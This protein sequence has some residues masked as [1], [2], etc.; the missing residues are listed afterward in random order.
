L[1]VSNY[2]IGIGNTAEGV[3]AIRGNVIRNLSAFGIDNDGFTVESTVAGI[4]FQG[5]NG[6]STDIARNYI[7]S[8]YVSSN[9]YNSY[10][11]GISIVMGSGELFNNI[12]R[13]GAE[14][15]T[16]S[17]VVG[18]LRE[19]GNSGGTQNNFFY[20]NTIYLEGTVLAQG[21][22]PSPSSAVLLRNGGF[23]DMNARL[24]NNN[25]YNHRT[26][27]L[28]L[29]Q[30]PSNSIINLVGY[31]INRVTSDYNNFFV[32][33]NYS[34]IASINAATYLN[35]LPA[36]Q[37]L[38]G[39]DANSLSINPGFANPGGILADDYRPSEDLFGIP[40]ALTNNITDDFR[41]N[42]IRPNALP[43]RPTMGAWEMCKV[44]ITDEP[45]NDG[46]CE[47]ETAT[48]TVVAV[49]S[50]TLTYQWQ[51][52]TDGGVTW[53]PLSN[54]AP[55]SGVTTPTLTITGIVPA[56]NNW[57]YKCIITS[58]VNIPTPVLW[59]CTKSEESL[60]ATLSVGT[61]PNTGLIY[62]Q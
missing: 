12:I 23:A 53:T 42:G 57:Q 56:M 34:A 25:F 50:G 19:G 31:D 33:G 40:G 8:L 51:V 41:Y 26:R 21:G 62:H 61:P 2:A 24:I 35:D 5:T 45:D 29:V 15:T 4:S 32:D 54:A 43:M 38:S 11:V 44:I 16:R 48:F 14:V 52:S 58:T 7:H 30:N 60:P 28:N 59:N 46:G 36:W 10:V 18:V 13:L 55:Y 47:G 6:G 20:F 3:M 27:E 39:E 37:A 22:D 9:D 49:G 1:Q 17:F